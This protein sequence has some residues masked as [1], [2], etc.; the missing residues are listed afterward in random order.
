MT[1]DDVVDVLGWRR[2][3]PEDARV[4][5]DAEHAEEVRRNLGRHHLFLDAPGGEREARDRERVGRHFGKGARLVPVDGVLKER[6]GAERVRCGAHVNEPKRAGLADAGRTEQQGVAGR[7]PH[8]RGGNRD[9]E[10]HHGGEREPPM[11][12]EEPEGVHGVDYSF[13]PSSQARLLSIIAARIGL[14]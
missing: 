11:P 12:S 2:I 6:R 8:D 5:R 7:Q 10:R 9:A 13:A 1:D 14:V 3:K 4:R